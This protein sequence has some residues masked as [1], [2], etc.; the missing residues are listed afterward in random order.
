MPWPVRLT[1]LEIE[2]SRARG[3][4]LFVVDAAYCCVYYFYLYIHLYIKM[5]GEIA[6]SVLY[7]Y[8][9]LFYTMRFAL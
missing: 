5:H 7:V 3:N 9:F 2:W 8:M 4:L 1:R 6:P